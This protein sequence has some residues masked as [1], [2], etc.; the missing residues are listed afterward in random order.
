MKA[1]LVKMSSL[2]DVIHALPA[3]TDAA[4]HGVTFDWVVEEAYATI[5]GR[6]PGVH[7][8]LPI[9]WRRWRSG[10]WRNRRA[11]G[12]FA[13]TLRA[14]RYDVVV[15]AQGLAKSAL[16]TALAR[17]PVKAGPGFSSA[18]EAVAAAFYDRRVDVPGDRHAVDRLRDLFA[19]VFGYS[20]AGLPEDF[21]LPARV[22]SGSARCLLLHGTTWPTKHWPEAMWRDL[23]ARLVATGLEVALPWGSSAERARAERIA[24]GLPGVEV[25]E[26]EPLEALAARIAASALVVGVDS[27]LAHLAGA[28]G[29][30][31][32]VIYGATSA[33]LTG[34]RGLRVVNR[35]SNLDCSP[36]LSRTCRYRG[37]EQTWRGEAVSPACYARVTPQEILEEVVELLEGR[38]G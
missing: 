11:L 4:A 27:G 20:L 22:R 21:G 6:H 37:V 34:C 18:R 3:V 33:G 10:L 38:S 24:A 16:V 25:L 30:P 9:A 35:Q 8:V 15:D 2:G 32:V 23:A 29:V 17:S 12:G 36:C 28:S 13:R 5:P 31:T 14:E 7:R 1:L 26:R 19:Q